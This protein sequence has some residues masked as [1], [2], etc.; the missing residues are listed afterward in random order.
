MAQA[1][2]P[3]VGSSL[4][5]L[6]Q[7][8]QAEIVIPE[9]NGIPAILLVA[10]TGREIRPTAVAFKDAMD[11]VAKAQAEVAGKDAP[12]PED[13]GLLDNLFR[14]ALEAGAVGALVAC[15]RDPGD[16]EARITEAQA[17]VILEAHAD[18]P[19]PQNAWRSAMRL[20]RIMDLDAY[21]KAVERE[22]ENRKAG[23]KKV[24]RKKATRKGSAGAAAPTVDF[25]TNGSSRK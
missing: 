1:S 12:S 9:A 11:E 7:A 3:L 24:S 16:S 14:D 25:P 19:T 22:A 8:L 23:K 10:P 18:L 17:Q 20:A 21:D 6:S 4:A 2:A 5:A 13:I 15:V